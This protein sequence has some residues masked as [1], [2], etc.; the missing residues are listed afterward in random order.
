MALPPGRVTPSAL[1]DEPQGAPRY[2][3]EG[4][5][6]GNPPPEL[7]SLGLGRGGE[8]DGTTR[9]RPSTALSLRVEEGRC[10]RLAPAPVMRASLRRGPP[11]RRLE[12]ESAANGVV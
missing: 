11:V 1:G 9:S 6:Q 8:G 3:S 4:T 2:L 5:V 12:H 7:P 10:G